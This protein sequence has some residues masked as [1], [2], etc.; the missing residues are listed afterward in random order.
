MEKGINLAL[1]NALIEFDSLL[2]AAIAAVSSKKLSVAD[3]LA[4]EDSSKFQVGNYVLIQND[5]DDETKSA[6]FWIGFGWEENGKYKPS[7]WLEFDAKTCPEKYWKNINELV[8]TS[9]K[10]YSKIDLEF[11]QEYMNSWIHFF[12]K[13]EHLKQF[14][15]ENVSLNTQKE[16]LTGFINEVLDKL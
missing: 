16:I 6:L 11:S 2:K 13:D 7:I 5:D 1:T 12:L 14:Y 8:G 10:H 9:G 4:G 15:E 3:E